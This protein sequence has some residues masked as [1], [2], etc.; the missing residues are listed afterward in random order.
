MDK[1]LHKGYSA[2]WLGDGC[3]TISEIATKELMRVTNHHLIPK[4]TE[5]IKNKTKNKAFLSVPPFVHVQKYLQLIPRSWNAKSSLTHSF[6]FNRHYQ[7]VMYGVESICAIQQMHW[8]LS[9]PGIS[10]L[11][12]FR[13]YHMTGQL[14]NRRVLWYLPFLRVQSYFSFFF[15]FFGFNSLDS[16]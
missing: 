14:T 11:H 10:A 1:R 9:L 8:S 4:T 13:W 3:I 15:K 5:I 2:H 16:I 6:D 7:L 12:R